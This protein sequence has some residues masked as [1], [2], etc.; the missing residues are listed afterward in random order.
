MAG[1]CRGVSAYIRTALGR[2]WSVAAL[3][4]SASET[5]PASLDW[6]AVEQV[7]TVASVLRGA[8][9]W[10]LDQPAQRFDAQDWWFRHEFDFPGEV[11]CGDSVVLLGMDG[12]ATLATVWLNGHRLLRST[13]MFH[14]HVCDVSHLL[15]PTGNALVIQFHSLD[16]DLK[17]KRK[18]ARWRVPM[19]EN[20]Q[21][22]WI[23]TTL[24]GRAPGWSPAVA[25]V[26]P[27]RDVWLE[28]RQLLNVSNVRVQATVNG[29]DGILR[30]SLDWT[31]LGEA[32]IQSAQIVLSRNG[33]DYRSEV[34][35]AGSSARFALTVP[36]ADLWWPHTHIQG[37]P[38]LYDLALIAALDG[39]PTPL[40]IDLGRVGFRTITVNTDEG[41]FS[42]QVN[43]VPVFC[44]GACWMPLDIASLSATPAA[45][46]QAIAQ[47]RAAG[48]NMLRVAGTTIYEH[49]AFWDA[50]DEA[51]ILVWQ[52]FMFANMDYPLD[53]AEFAASVEC[54]VRQ[55][56]TR[57]SAR[58]SLALLCGN[59]EVAQQAAMWG[60]PKSLWSVPFFDTTLP[61]I[62][63]ELAPDCYYWPSS[64]YGGAFPFQADTGT[65]SYYGVGAYMRAPSDARTSHLRFATE[66]LAFANVPDDAALERMPGGLG[67][68]VHHANWKS[69]T[70]RDLGAGWDFD[71]VRDHYLQ[72]LWG[73]DPLKLR[74]ADHDRYLQLSR[75]VSGE[76]MAQA[77]AQWRRSDSVC[78]G[79]LILYLQDLW[80]AAGWGVL[81][82]QGRPKPCFYF[83]KRTLQPLFIGLAQAD[84]DGLWID[85]VNEEPS[86][87]AVLLEVTAWRQG[88][89]KAA[90]A[91]L[92]L[93]LPPR[94]SQRINA[95]AL[96]DH[97]IDFTHAYRF[98]PAFCDTVVARL[99]GENQRQLA[100]AFY[101]R[102]PEV[103]SRESDLQLSGE[104]EWR[105]A[106]TA[107]LRLKTQRFARYVVLDAPGFTAS[108]NYFHLAPEMEA[109]VTLQC[110]APVAPDCIVNLGAVNT[111]QTV[112]L[113]LKATS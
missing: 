31:P 20:Q 80:P 32:V 109:L 50:C 106:T 35:F 55:Q 96:F 23:R 112:R 2:G 71:D 56:V 78:R 97:F 87:K 68:R 30:G 86:Q 110:M 69:R 48:M 98:G 107:V 38:A 5:V 62:C 36:Q 37:D 46:R 22:R 19:L 103:L 12:L 9:D 58:P 111:Y 8:G 82:D 21:L 113:V 42:V 10:A 105:D 34:E 13:N 39:V 44:R 63:A 60:A 28:K 17:A 29:A 1:I 51:G 47:V 81:D 61:A 33:V 88:N 65:T 53:D 3:S 70:P 75:L 72:S 100:A 11:G 93:E 83:L 7:G 16:A 4:A 49:D 26:G 54:E 101:S 66:C 40:V 41:E 85:L 84:G 102:E 18:R 95:Q 27:W 74:Y 108:D 73:V 25:T 14:A 57:I 89:V 77:Y 52:D 91:S 59:S 45:Y 94:Q 43:G 24:L 104:M 64:A 6:R 79:A 92:A 15:Q 90:S 76:A 67:A 99:L